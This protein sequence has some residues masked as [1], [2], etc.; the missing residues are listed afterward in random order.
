MDMDLFKSIVD[1]SVASGADRIFLGGYGEPLIDPKLAERIAYVKSKGLF[2]N[3]ISNASLWTEE[4]SRE[5]I[6][7]GLDEVRFSVYGVSEKTYEDVHVNLSHEETTNNIKRLAAMERKNLQVLVF[8]LVLENNE[9]EMEPFIKEWK[10][11]VDVVEVWRPHNWSN[12]RDYRDLSLDAKPKRTC[13]RPATGPLQV[14]WDGTCIPCCWDYNGEMILGDLKKQSIAELFR[15]PEYE[16]IR[17]DHASGKFEDFP[18]C[19]G[20]DQ[21]HEHPDAI[22]YSS[23]Q[24]DL[25]LAVEKTNSALFELK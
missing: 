8:F 1:D 6:D 9:N 22:V 17:N 13:G 11:V 23:R 12:G 20:C 15:S 16:K 10:D 4:K 25:S 5:L 21:L 14:Q 2:C 19:D 18:F 24:T 7:A 3:F